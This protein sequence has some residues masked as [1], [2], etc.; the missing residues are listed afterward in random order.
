MSRQ[1]LADACNAELDRRY[2]A[3]GKRPRWAGMTERAIGTL[4]R[5]EIRWPNEDYRKALCAVLGQDERGLGL[6]I[7]RPVA[8]GDGSVTAAHPNTSRSPIDHPAGEIESGSI[9]LR[10][11]VDGVDIVVPLSRRQLLQAGAGSVVEA[12]APGQHRDMLYEMAS[13]QVDRLAITSSAHLDEVLE[14]LREQWHAL[15]R[16]DNLLGPRFALAG[17]MNQ[18]A[19]LDALRP[20]LRGDQRLAVIRLGAKYAESAAWLFEDTSNLGKARY[21]TTRA[22][23]WAYEGDDAPM[24]AWTILG[25]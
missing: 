24:L 14:H 23:E 5:G 6:Y 10:L 22:M 4:E 20:S 17:V 13:R 2:E 21:W 19:V 7:D 12:L 16:T 25:R 1:E 15:V 9:Q 18:I 3:Q 8:E 11:Q